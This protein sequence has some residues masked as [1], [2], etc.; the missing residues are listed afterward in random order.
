MTGSSLQRPSELSQRHDPAELLGHFALSRSLP[1]EPVGW[2]RRSLDSWTLMHEPRLPVLALVDAAGAEIGWIV[3]HPI[4]LE[5]ELVVAGPLRPPSHGFEEWLYTFGGRFV[6]IVLGPEPM[7]YPDAGATLP[8]LFDPELRCAASSPFLLP[9]PDGL[10]PDSSLVDALAVFDTG[11]WFT[12]GATPHARARLLLPNHVLDLT[13]WEQARI[14]P[15]APFDAG[16]IDPLVE[17]VAITLEKTLAAAAAT[18]RPNVAITA[19]RDSRSF[20]AC[21]RTVVDR[22]RFFTVPVPDELGAVDIA[23]APTLAERFGLEYRLLPWREPSASDVELFMYRTGCL[24]GEAR[25]RTATRTYDQLGGGDIYV[26]GVGAPREIAWRRR[27]TPGLRLRPED[28]LLRYGLL[29]HPDLVRQA[30]DWLAAL[31]AGLDGLDALTLFYVEM[32]MGAWGGPLTTAYPD[33]YS[34]T[35]Y[36]YAHRAITDA[37]LRLPWEYRRAGRLPQDVIA[38]RWPELL[39][40]PINRPPLRIAVRRGARSSVRGA[41]A[42]LGRLGAG[43]VRRWVARRLNRRRAL[44]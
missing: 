7:L 31:P 40:V 18:G 6:A 9:S 26:S 44:R 34:F 42:G 5:S 35:L 22:L 20:L 24:I 43:K 11:S 37:V 13:G 29:P 28:L 16:E 4:D 27:D 30:A 39:D 25:G 36:P 1:L 12:L 38:S 41:R 3:G 32:R 14:W 2:P 19:G 21:S 10:V 23:T 17:R 8:V 15:L 33:A